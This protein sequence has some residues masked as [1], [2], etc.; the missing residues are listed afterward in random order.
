MATPPRSTRRATWKPSR[1]ISHPAGS[2]SDAPALR[3]TWPS[4]AP[5][6]V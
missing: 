6:E 5:A 2:T 3:P 1:L 4:A